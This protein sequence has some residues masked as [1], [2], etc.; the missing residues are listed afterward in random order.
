M[1]RTSPGAAAFSAARRGASRPD[2]SRPRERAGLDVARVLRQARRDVGPGPRHVLDDEDPVGGLS[3]PVEGPLCAR[4]PDRPDARRGAEGAVRLEGGGAVGHPPADDHGVEA[5]DAG[6]AVEHAVAPLRAGVVAVG[7]PRLPDVDVDDAARALGEEVQGPP[8]LLGGPAEGGVPRGGV[9]VTDER[10]RQRGPVGGPDPA[11]VRG[12]DGRRV[13]ADVAGP[14][15]RAVLPGLLR[16]VRFAQLCGVRGGRWA[17]AVRGRGTVDLHDR[18]LLGGPRGRDD[19]LPADHGRGDGPGRRRRRATW[20]RA[21]RP[22]AASAAS[23][24]AGSAPGAGA[25]RPRGGWRRQARRTRPRRPARRARGRA[26]WSRR[27]HRSWPRPIAPW[28]GRAPASATGTTRRRSGRRTAGPHPRGRATRRRREGGRR[29][30]R[31]G[32]CRGPGRARRC[33]GRGCSRP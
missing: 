30:R 8:P 7:G 31:A 14:G 4:G 32:R 3:E 24:R 21:P 29:R 6:H 16:G 20:R 25:A 2:C 17:T 26:T 27:A 22:P 19:L 5:L 11:L 28:P 33:R 1:V 15:V 9:G 12:G 18:L 23:T 10:D 13:V